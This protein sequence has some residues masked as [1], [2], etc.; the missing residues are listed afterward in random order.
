MI[1]STKSIKLTIILM[2]AMGLWYSSSKLE[3]FVSNLMLSLVLALM[4]FSVYIQSLELFFSRN[5]ITLITFVAPPAAVVI[6]ET[7]KLIVF[8]SKREKVS[9]L[10]KLVDHDFWKK[11]YTREE[12]QIFN[13]C[14][15]FCF[16]SITTCVLFMSGTCSNY[17]ISPIIGMITNSTGKREFPFP[18]RF[19]DGAYESPLFELF[20]VLEFL[21]TLAVGLCISTFTCYSFVINL[22]TATQFRILNLNLQSLCD[23][24]ENCKETERDKY[25]LEALQ[26]LRNHIRRHQLLIGMTKEIEDLYCY[27]MLEQI[28]GSVSQTCFLGIQILLVKSTYQRS[29]LAVIFL[30]S[31]FIQLY[32]YSYSSEAVFEASQDVSQAI[33]I[34]KWFKITHPKVRK[35]FKQLMMIVAIRARRP[36]ILTVG[37][38]Y[39]LSVSTFTS[40]I[41]SSMSYFTILRKLM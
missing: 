6:T 22:F 11:S 28:F 10:N 33:S 27:V 15:N 18:I 41:G 3:K 26:K 21:A 35:E 19:H 23:F 16:K 38:F 20:F 40:V 17:I 31:S 39:P 24:D 9:K 34:T 12:E 30:L 14:N 29:F 5:S 1:E 8:V 32:F 13:D 4:I 36:C 37:K 25:Q 7:S 2:R